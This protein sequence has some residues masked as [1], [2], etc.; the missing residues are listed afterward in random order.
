MNY[1]KHENASHDP[2]VSARR[3]RGTLLQRRALILG[4]LAIPCLLIIVGV[5]LGF[6]ALGVPNLGITLG[7]SFTAAFAFLLSLF[8]FK[9]YLL[10][11]NPRLRKASRWTL[12]YSYQESVLRLDEREKLVI[13]QAYRTSYEILALVCFL[14][15][16]CLFFNTATWHLAYRLGFAGSYCI[17]LGVVSLL[18]YLPVTVVAWHESV[19]VQEEETRVP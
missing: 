16:F 19:W 15:T 7:I 10:K 1:V 18:S 5:G 14:L 13:D 12:R 2:I 8:L 11:D 6:L 9:P 17:F 3:D 4:F